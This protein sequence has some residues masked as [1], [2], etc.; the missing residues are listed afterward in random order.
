MCRLSC[1]Y[2]DYFFFSEKIYERKRKKGEKKRSMS[3]NL[4]NF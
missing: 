2:V 4:N 3:M 1:V